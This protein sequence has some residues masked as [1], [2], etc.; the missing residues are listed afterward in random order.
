MKPM[1]V[2]RKYIVDKVPSFRTQSDAERWIAE[3]ILLKPGQEFRLEHYYSG[4]WIK[5]E[6]DSNSGKTWQSVVNYGSKNTIY[7]IITPDQLPLLSDAER[8]NKKRLILSHTP[9]EGIKVEIGVGPQFELAD[10]DESEE[11]ERMEYRKNVDLTKPIDP[12]PPVK[13]V[14]NPDSIFDL[15]NLGIPVKETSLLK[16]G[17]GAWSSEEVNENVMLGAKLVPN[18]TTDLQY[19]NV[20][21]TLGNRNDATLF[22]KYN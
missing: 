14:R 3:D 20:K 13:T 17:K 2:L 18:S 6:Q 11:I 4:K 1:E 15:Q 21:I 8:M 10:M 22:V 19:D 16:L 12:P 7:L 5:R 9:L